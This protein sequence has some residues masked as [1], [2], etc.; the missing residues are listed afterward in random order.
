MLDVMYEV[1]ASDDIAGVKITRPV[2]L[3]ETK[4]SC[5]ASPI[6]PPPE[7]TRAAAGPARQART[8]AI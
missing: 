3:G 1:P 4:P 8:C 2:V 5:G 7:P 6:K